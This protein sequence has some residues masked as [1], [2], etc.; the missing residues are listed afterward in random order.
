M[1][2]VG[3]TTGDTTGLDTTGY[4]A[5]MPADPS[6]GRPLLVVPRAKYRLQKFVRLQKSDQDSSRIEPIRDRGLKACQDFPAVGSK[7]R[8]MLPGDKPVGQGIGSS[9]R[10]L[11]SQLPH[12]WHGC[13]RSPETRWCALVVEYSV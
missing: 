13:R 4:D 7:I 9:S 12:N 3:T 5:F 1:E 11:R 2:G 10:S 8:S 6:L